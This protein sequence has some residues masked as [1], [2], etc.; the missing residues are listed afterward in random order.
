M[1]NT[2]QTEIRLDGWCESGF[3]QQKDNGGGCATMR[4]IGRSGER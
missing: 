2:M 3:G 1:A 4:K